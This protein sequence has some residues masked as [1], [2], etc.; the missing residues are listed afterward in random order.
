LF[1]HLQVLSLKHLALYQLK[2]EAYSNELFRQQNGNTGKA[3]I[4]IELMV[5]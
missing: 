2:I 3:G 5:F 1:P 4:T